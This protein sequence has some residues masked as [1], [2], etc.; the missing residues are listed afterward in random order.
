MEGKHTTIVNKSN[1]DLIIINHTNTF[2]YSIQD[3][4]TT[5]LCED[6]NYN[7]DYEELATLLVKELN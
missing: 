1:D 6:N 2:D 7:N 5:K 3:K 4:M